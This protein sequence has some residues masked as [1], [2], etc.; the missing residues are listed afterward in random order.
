MQNDF[1]IV[2]GDKEFK[3]KKEIVNKLGSIRHKDHFH[4]AYELYLL[5]QGDVDFQIEQ[6]RYSL[7]P[8][9]VLIIKPGQHHTA[10]VRSNRPYERIVVRFTSSDIS[11]DLESQINNL[12]VV[13]N[14]RGLKS[15]ASYS[16]LL[17]VWQN[18]SESC[19]LDALEFQT[20]LILCSLCSESELIHKSKSVSKELEKV[21]SFIDKN[22]VSIHSEEDICKGLGKS[23]SALRKL[24]IRNLNTSVMSYVRT[25][26]CMLADEMLKSGLSP[27]QV[28][29]DCGFKYYSTF[30]RD[31]IKTFGKSPMK[32]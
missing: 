2:N 26:K 1:E 12:P 25:K 18:M 20:G 14:I 19:L 4:K 21:I 31:Y 8:D 30:Y 9:D 7:N 10:I 13:F 24:F 15:K 16:N 29:I 6:N 23:A 22:L 28:A 27:H 3:Y 5:L 11:S 17:D 32:H